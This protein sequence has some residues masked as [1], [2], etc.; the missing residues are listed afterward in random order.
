M[1]PPKEVGAPKD[2]NG[3]S[4]GPTTTL[5]IIQSTAKAPNTTCRC[6]FTDQVCTCNFYRDWVVIWAARDDSVPD[7]LRRRRAASYRLPRLACG[8]RDPISASLR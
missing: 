7:Q 3:S 6:A 5:T 4:S 2:P 1:S 8:K